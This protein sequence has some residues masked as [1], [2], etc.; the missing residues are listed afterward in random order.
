MERLAE[1]HDLLV[2]MEENVLKGGFGEHL[3]TMLME[4]ESHTDILNIA[5]PDIYVEHGNVDV[6]KKEIGLDAEFIV[7]RILE[8]IGDNR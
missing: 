3:C 2:T 5:I 1:S 7:N 6:L 4:V 8:R